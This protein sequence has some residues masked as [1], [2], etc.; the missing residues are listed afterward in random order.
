MPAILY[1][2]NVARA[3]QSLPKRAENFNPAHRDPGEMVYSRGANQLGIPS[4]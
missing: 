4:P 3:I 1:R 2:L